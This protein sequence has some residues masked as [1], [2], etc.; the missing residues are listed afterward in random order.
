MLLESIHLT[1]YRGH[2]DLTVRFGPHFNVL[3]GVNG[4]GKSSL[5]NAICDAMTSYTRYLQIQNGHVQPLQGT[6]VVRIEVQ[7]QAGRLRFEPQFPVK[8]SATGV[9]FSTRC[10]WSISKSNA[11]GN[12][13]FEG[14]SPGDAWQAQQ[15]NS[16]TSSGT[17]SGNSLP[18]LA[19]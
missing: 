18:M 2:R 1:N 6:N 7:D 3:V 15:R 17:D 10:K 9:A 16:L 11:E 8:I 19:F 4:S 5:L 12:P 14:S 13:L